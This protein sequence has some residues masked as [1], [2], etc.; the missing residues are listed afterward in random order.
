MQL[1][2]WLDRPLVLTATFALL[3]T[4]ALGGLHAVSTGAG[5]TSLVVAS[6]LEKATLLQQAAGDFNSQGSQVGSGCIHVRVEPVASGDAEQGLLGDWPRQLGE[7]P[8]VWSPAATAWILLSHQHRQ[9]RGLPPIADTD[10]P[11]LFQSPLVVAMPEPMARAMG[12]PDHPIGWS[13]IYQL[14]QDPNGWARYGHPEWGAFRLGKTS[15]DVSTS[16]LHSLIGTYFAASGK[17]S[18]LTE[19]DLRDAKV[20]SFVKAVESSVVHYGDTAFTFLTNLRA[21]DQRDT[22]L[23]YVSAVAVEEKEVWNYNR[24]NVT[25]DPSLG[26][27]SLPPRIPLA[28]VYPRE[29][30][31]FA[32]HPFAVLD[33]NWVSPAKRRAA[34]R[35]LSYLSSPSRQ[36]AFQAQGF[37][38]RFGVAGAEIS[39]RYDLD[40]RKPSTVLRLPSPPVLAAV[41]ASWDTLRKRARLL[42][43]VDLSA[44][45]GAP[46][47]AAMRSPLIASLSELGDDDEVGLW[48]TPGS[49]AGFDQ[50]VSVAPLAADRGLLKSSI[51]GLSPANHAAAVI[52]A[53]KAGSASLGGTEFDSSRIQAIILISAGRGLDPVQV[54]PLL[55]QL[56]A[57][58]AGRLIRVFTV[59]DGNQPDTTTLARIALASGAGYYRANSPGAFHDLLLAVL[60]NF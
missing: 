12:W 9:A 23:S 47:L 26:P 54:D 56:L 20:T 35:F 1:T 7:R 16:G 2:S 41:Q 39:S 58:P 14:A 49:G 51:D 57:Q 28:A 8:D 5:C 27:T 19:Q 59:A 17:T 22:S 13:E 10:S 25:G 21:A 60:S 30:T 33:G 53:V 52:D 3:L 50:V 36:R 55:R 38:D 31:L 18:D 40:P 44:A 46:A 29:G 32:D 15:P 42:I 11:S 43:I 24:G 4:G 34:D 6:S 37:R 48:E 45:V